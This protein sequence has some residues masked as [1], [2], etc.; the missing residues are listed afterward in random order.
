M[1]PK[2][3]MSKTA[4]AKILLLLLI[5]AACTLGGPT[6]T[7]EAVSTVRDDI[8]LPSSSL[9]STETTAATPADVKKPFTF[10]SVMDKFAQDIAGVINLTTSGTESLSIDHEDE[11]D[12]FDFDDEEDAGYTDTAV[13]SANDAHRLLA[14]EPCS[15]TINIDFSITDEGKVLEAGDYV[16]NE[17]KDEFGVRISASGKNDGG[18][19]PNGKARILDSSNPG[20]SK[21]LGTPNFKCPNRGPGK[22]SG[23]KPGRTG[24][25]CESQGNVLII[26]DT[27]PATIR[28][29]SKGGSINFSF[30]KPTEVAT[31]GLLDINSSGTRIR[32]YK[33]DGS[34]ITISAARL[35]NNSFQEV[36]IYQEGVTRIRIDLKSN[37]AITD[38]NLCAPRTPAPTPQP[39][40]GGDCVPVEVIHTEDFEEG[41][42]SGWKHG[43]I[44]S[45]PGFTKFLGRF[46]KDDKNPTKTFRAP[47]EAAFVELE[48]DFYEIDRYVTPSF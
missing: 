43:K 13:Y 7:V 42:L 22:G 20:E 14:Q 12:D 31:L 5:G 4:S 11:Y 48:F 16:A 9:S 36:P 3:T 33:S 39:T 6:L 46:I 40:L 25:N 15:A 29:F 32:I 21:E 23:G 34:R 37:G 27:D 44:D 28:E 10:S 1:T 17:W 2:K 24:E 19:T 18:Y 38:L 26:Q 35:G 47:K 41:S 30:S 45:D 8:E